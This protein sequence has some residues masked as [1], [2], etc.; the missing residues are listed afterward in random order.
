M[1]RSTGSRYLERKF[2]Y[3]GLGIFLVDTNNA[4][5]EI[6][7]I[8]MLW[9]V[10]HLWLS[11]A[12]FVFNWYCNYAFIIFRH[13]NGTNSFMHNMEGMMQGYPLA[14]IAYGRGILP[15][16]KNLKREIPGVTHPL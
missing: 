3:G 1:A 16:I 13:G 14:M 10:R 4:L 5:N 6:D 7:K 9:T 11:R 2:D 8:G 15:L 12:C